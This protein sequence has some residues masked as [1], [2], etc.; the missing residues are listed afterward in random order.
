MTSERWGQI[1]RLYHAALELVAEERDAFLDRACAGDGDLRREVVSLLASYDQAGGFME[2]PPADVVAGMLA[3][4]RLR[5]MT[6]RTLGHYKIQSL[7]GAGG[8]GEVYRARDTRLGRDVAVKILPEHLAGDDDAL[9]RFEREAKAVAALSHPNILSI[10]DFGIEEGVSYAVTELLEGETLRQRLNR[11]PLDWRETIEAGVAIAEGLAATHAGGIIHRDLK[12]E[13]IFLTQDGRVK[14]LDFGIARVRR[15]VSAEAET[16]TS[17]FM[18]TTRPGVFMG[19]LGYMSPEQMRG[20]AVEAP[21]DIFSLGCVMHEMLSGEQLFVRNT[22]AET[23]AAILKEEPPP[24]Q[25]CAR[26][27][28]AELGLI[29]NKALQKGRDDRYQT[30]GDLLVDLKSLKLELE[31]EAKLK[32]AGQPGNRSLTEASRPDS[33]SAAPA[34][35]AIRAA[36]NTQS[37][38][39][40]VIS[41]RR[42][43]KRAIGIAIGAAILFLG[44]VTAYRIWIQN[45]ARAGKSNSTPSNTSRVEVMRY[46]LEVESDGGATTPL[47][48][49]RKFRFHFT[50]RNRGYLY[51]IA[52]GENNVPTTFL[53]SQPIAE[54]GVTTNLVEAGVDYSFPRGAGNGIE[55]GHYGNVTTFTIIFSPAPL[56]KPGFLPARAYRQLTADEQRELASFWQ[57]F[58]KQSPELVPQPDGHQPSTAVTIS[59]ERANDEPIIFDIPLKRR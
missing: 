48:A 38:T 29:V 19:T 7:L 55:L 46:Y 57:Q 20:E 8:M 32:G 35:A 18:K 40:P 17:T 44:S 14:I 23:I 56:A 21:S 12:P 9:R 51:I 42:R 30:A 15:V 24:L 34:Q 33:S 4:K 39:A 10:F 3:G 50:P 25:Q 43:M 1:E 28:P 2:S 52:A 13:N 16:V 22:A 6:G 5:S 47:E 59:T 58:G 41:S 54:T 45:S 27:I 49:G 37:E 31:L 26:E 36:L 53:T 11:S